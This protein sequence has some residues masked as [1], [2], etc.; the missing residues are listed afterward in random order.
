MSC[1]YCRT[2]NTVCFWGPMKEKPWKRPAL[3]VLSVLGSAGFGALLWLSWVN[4]EGI[5]LMAL[6]GFLVAASILG[7]LVSLHGCNACVARLFGSA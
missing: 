6:A 5:P 7:I 2:V 1:A 3:F 4:P